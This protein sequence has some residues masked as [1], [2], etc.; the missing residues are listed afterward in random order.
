M[1]RSFLTALQFLTIVPVTIKGELTAREMAAS[2]VYFPVVG[3]LQGLLL[4]AAA[5]FMAPFF[6]VPV[7]AGLIVTLLLVMSGGFHLDGLADTFDATS[8]K[9][10]GDVQRDRERRLSVMKDSNIGA[11]G[12]MALVLSILLKYLFVE[13]AL[14][15]GPCLGPYALLVTPVF[16]KWVMVPSL[17]HG[18]AA[19]KEGLAALFIGHVRRPALLGASLWLVLLFVVPTMILAPVGPVTG[20]KVFVLGF[21]SV[22]ALGL[23]W[24]AFCRRRFGGLT[25][26]NIGAISEM[27]EPLF[28]AITLLLL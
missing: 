25:G 24:T 17:Y 5:H 1:I 3:A 2:V 8:V 20:L 12:A 7:T 4:F 26:D 21:C 10:T 9:S 6:P 22:Y 27:S 14:R 16:S 19:K 18:T 28:L 13:A 15:T 23:A 11:I